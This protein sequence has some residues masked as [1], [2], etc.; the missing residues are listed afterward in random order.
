MTIWTILKFPS[1]KDFFDWLKLRGIH[2]YGSVVMESKRTGQQHIVSVRYSLKLSA[3]DLKRSEIVQCEL[4]F[5]VGLWINPEV[6][7][8][9]AE[10]AEKKMREYV[11]TAHKE[12]FKDYEMK[13]ILA[14]FLSGESAE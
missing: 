2:E 14:E 11:E 4:F 9:E 7:R 8:K 10:A 5:W 3:K 6:S 12:A 1:A 13:V